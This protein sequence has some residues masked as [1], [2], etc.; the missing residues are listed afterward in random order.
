[1]TCFK[2]RIYPEL[3]E[4]INNSPIPAY[5]TDRNGN[6]ILS[7][8]SA[9]KF[10]FNGIDELNPK[11]NERFDT[12]YL[13][14]QI[15]KGNNEVL[16][17]GKKSESEFQL[18][19]VNGEKY[20]YK[21][22]KIPMKNF[23]G[24]Y[25]AIATFLR[26][27]DAEKRIQEQRET[28][29]ATLSHDLKTPAIAQVRALELLLSGQLGEFNSE[30]KELLKLTLDSC[31]YMYDMVYSL[32]STY[33]FESGEV[34]LNYSSFN[35][36]EIIKESI[37]EIN[38][39]AINNSIKINFEPEEKTCIVFADKA[40]IKR[41]LINFLSN[42]I[43]YAFSSSTIKVKL[44]KNIEKAE[45]RII[46]SSPY[47]AP[48]VMQR[49]FSKYVTHSEKF[50]KVGV[51]LGL[52]LS[53]KII[54]AHNGIVIAESSKEFSSNTFGFYIPINLSQNTKIK[55]EFTMKI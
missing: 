20:W 53:K 42:S 25:Y 29:I 22:T 9:Q 43:N 6:I 15:I 27:I 5:I 23:N 26:N 14:N 49:I 18:Q 41:V 8:Q 44:S 19:T 2:N 28:Y 45:L 31:N 37:K 1:M 50:N 30:Q 35:L 46:N 36:V 3:Y 54:E 34:I 33:K 11:L 39:L 7:N 21:Y 52:Y 12:I 48:D 32:L 17:D 47:I 4:L 40:E 13:K 55:E 16:L 24:E 38:E 10:F 51:G